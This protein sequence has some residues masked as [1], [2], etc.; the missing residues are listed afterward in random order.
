MGKNPLYFAVLTLLSILL[1]ATIV[2]F[3]SRDVATHSQNKNQP[4]ESTQ[5]E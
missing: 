4:I 5:G 3:L 2:N 1:I